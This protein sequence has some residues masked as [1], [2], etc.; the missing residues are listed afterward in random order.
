MPAL[1]DMAWPWDE[2]PVCLVTGSAQ[3]LGRAVA[4]ALAQRGATVLRA[5]LIICVRGCR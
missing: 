3:G 1:E 2:P 5:C 4:E